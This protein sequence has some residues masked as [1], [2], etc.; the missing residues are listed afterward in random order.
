MNL[1]TISSVS[2]DR[3]APEAIER[4]GYT[5]LL[6]S[7]NKAFGLIIHE[8]SGRIFQILNNDGAKVDAWQVIETIQEWSKQ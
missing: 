3:M 2:Y 6:N 5:V 4:A 1:F 8:R 7:E